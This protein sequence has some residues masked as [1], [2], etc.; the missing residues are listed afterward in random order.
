MNAGIIVVRGAGRPMGNPSRCGNFYLCGVACRNLEQMPT[1]T[2]S[3]FFRVRRR[4]VPAFLCALCASMVSV[5]Y[6]FTFLPAVRAQQIDVATLPARDTH[7]GLTV[8]V[9]PYTDA[10]RSKERF[11]KKHPYQA[12]L[13]AVE[14]IIRNDN[15]RPVRLDLKEL[16]LLLS[17][18]GN[19]R[20]RLA[21]LELDVVIEKILHKEQGGPNPTVSRLPIPR[22]RPDRSKDWKEIEARLAPAVFI[23]DILPPQA[24]VRGFLFFDLARR[25]EWVPYGRLYV[26]DLKFMDD[27]QA[28]FYFEV[29]L[30]KAARP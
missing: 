12:G 22:R 25:F 23:N 16:R 20:Q 10:A 4:R 3:H 2:T 14:V 9:D 8:A 24:T 26:P 17:P 27:G 7:E 19:S 28:L 29:D 21:P 18:P 1:R 5:L 30:S 15:T 6:L 11:G 13:L